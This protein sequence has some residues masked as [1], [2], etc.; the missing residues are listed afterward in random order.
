VKQ[1]LIA[2]LLVG[3]TSVL[4]HLHVA[5]QSYYPVVQVKSPE[6]LV[7]TAVHEPLSERRACAE[8]NHRFLAPFKSM[9]GD[10]RIVVARC[11]REMEG[12]KAALTERS[13]ILQHL[14][15]A[16]GLQLAIS[17]PEAAASSSCI[18]IA[19]SSADQGIRCMPPSRPPYNFQAR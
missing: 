9:C 1:A 7:F 11:E 13:P 14:I 5:A 6:G 8:A 17:G 18:H 12:V 19:R 2:V 4:A 10:C 15:L 3:V 16:P